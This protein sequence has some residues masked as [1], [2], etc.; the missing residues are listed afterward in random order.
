MTHDVLQTH[1][2]K[3]AL[4]LVVKEYVIV[5]ETCIANCDSKT[6]RAQLRSVDD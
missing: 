1:V 2:V 5:L 6:A 4:H 3:L